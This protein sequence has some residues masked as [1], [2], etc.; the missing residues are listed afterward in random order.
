[1]CMGACVRAR[2]FMS[3]RA[4]G[5]VCMHACVHAFMCVCVC[6]HDGVSV[7]VGYVWFRTAGFICEVISLGR[8]AMLWVGTLRGMD[9]GEY[10]NYN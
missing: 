2:A 10:K 7:H 6:M 8:V 9:D 1:M 3:V 5:P 4:C